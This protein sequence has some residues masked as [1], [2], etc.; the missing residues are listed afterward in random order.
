MFTCSV[1][2]AR[3][4]S[5]RTRDGV[6]YYGVECGCTLK[7]PSNYTLEN[8]SESPDATEINGNVARVKGIGPFRINVIDSQ[9]NRMASI[10]F[11]SWNIILNKQSVYRNDKNVGTEFKRCS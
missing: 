11:F 2:F 8:S 3:N 9:N 4:L 1:S 5:T 6:T 7:F 10:D